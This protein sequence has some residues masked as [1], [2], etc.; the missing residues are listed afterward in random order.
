M[1]AQIATVFAPFIVAL[2]STS[3]ILPHKTSAFIPLQR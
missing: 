1:Y 2:S 3:E